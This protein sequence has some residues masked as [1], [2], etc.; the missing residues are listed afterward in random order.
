MR[1]LLLALSACSSGAVDS[2]SPPEE[3]SAPSCEDSPSTIA[4]DA[5]TDLGVSGQ[6]L[7]ERAGALT[8]TEL[9]WV[10]TAATTALSIALSYGGE[11]RWVDSTEL[12]CSDPEG[13]PA[14]AASCED[15]LEVDVTIG[16]Q[17]AD[18]AFD[19]LWSATLS[20]AD[21]RAATFGLAIDPDSLGGDWSPA[22]LDPDQY[23]DFSISAAGRFDEGGPSGSI[24]AQG[25]GSDGEV[26]WAES[27]DIARWP[28][29]DEL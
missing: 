9:Y 14:I 16:F 19:E 1:F 3:A 28:A 20:S 13:C 25:S 27:I 2:A 4:S 18:G 7:L 10:D 5:P 17:T 8:E 12:P 23:E 24:R 6:D 11:T 21:G 22:A 29:A 26:S 15:R